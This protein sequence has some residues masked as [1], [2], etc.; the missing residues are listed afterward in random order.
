M[1]QPMGLQGQQGLAMEHQQMAS[2]MLS[3]GVESLQQSIQHLPLG[4][5]QKS[6]LIPITEDG[7][8]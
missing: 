4:P 3:S 1:L 6:L 8:T 2:L 5:L 7:K